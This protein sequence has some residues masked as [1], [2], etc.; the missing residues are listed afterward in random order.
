MKAPEEVHKTLG[1]WKLMKENDVTHI[2]HLKTR[3]FNMSSMVAT[4]GL[5]PHQA[6]VAL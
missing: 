5:L 2:N 3:I 6:D 4:S 1:V